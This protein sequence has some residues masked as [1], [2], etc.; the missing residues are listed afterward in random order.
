M[1]RITPL[2]G[3]QAP[4]GARVLNW[5]A[6]RKFGQELAP[7]GIMAYNPGFILPYLGTTRFVQGRTRL[8]PR[9][10]LLATQ[11]VAL[12]NGCSWCI[13]FGRSHAAA[14]GLTSRKLAA[15][16]DHADNPRFSPAEQAALA[17]ADAVTQVG[18]HVSDELFARL[19]VHFDE[20]EIVE[21][22]IAVATEN[23]YNRFNSALGVESQGFCAVPSLQPLTRRSA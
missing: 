16:I 9:V 19:R 6:S 2:T 15:V 18:A 12:L 3:R 14:G 11:L 4:I 17:Y 7:L 22:T 20:R 1:S 5:L 21:L 10:R 23:L 13:D 8:D